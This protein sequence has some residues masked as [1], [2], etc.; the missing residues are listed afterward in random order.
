MFLDV[1]EKIKN[2]A[3]LTRDLEKKKTKR[4]INKEIKKEKKD[5]SK[6]IVPQQTYSDINI[7][8]ILR[9]EEKFLLILVKKSILF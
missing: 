8:T 2:E 3:K 9:D 6:Y 1:E 4:E 7:K 5:F